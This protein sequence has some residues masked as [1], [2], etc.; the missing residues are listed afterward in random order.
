MNFFV[1]L[2]PV[3]VLAVDVEVGGAAVMRLGQDPKPI[4]PASLNRADYTLSGCADRAEN[5]YSETGRNLNFG[6]KRFKRRV[7]DDLPDWQ[8]FGFP[9]QSLFS[10]KL[11]LQDPAPRRQTTT[12]TSKFKLIRLDKKQA[13]AANDAGVIRQQF[14]DDNDLHHDIDNDATFGPLN[15]EAGINPIKLIFTLTLKT[16]W[17]LNSLLLPV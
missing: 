8:I 2:V 7:E 14:E 4:S 9:P 15:A 5:C 11:L 1:F 6:A 17:S 3:F 13:E 12:T 10:P 16:F